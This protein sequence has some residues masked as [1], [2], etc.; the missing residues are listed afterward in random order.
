MCLRGI[1]FAAAPVIFFGSLR[2][3]LQPSASP[4]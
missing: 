1:Q 4:T 2:H 3:Y